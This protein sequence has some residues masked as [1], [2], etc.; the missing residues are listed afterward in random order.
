[1]ALVE[2]WRS[3]VAANPGLLVASVEFGLKKLGYQCIKA[4]QLSA[5]EA[6]LKGNHVFVSIPTGFGKSLTY[7]LL[8]FCAES[9][10]QS[11][12]APHVVPI[13]VVV[14]SLLS[15][16]YNQM[17]KLSS[18]HIKAVCISAAASKSDD[19]ISTIVGSGVT[20]IFGSPEAIVGSK[21]WRSLFMDDSFISRIVAIVIDEAHCIVKW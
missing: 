4:E 18:K 11:T 8:P 16:M 2:A 1:M 13:V 17:T 9:L 21:K 20:H 6:V 15:L 12:S 3:K 10:L 19:L 14:S 7:R 5:V